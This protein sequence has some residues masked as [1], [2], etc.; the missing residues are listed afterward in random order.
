MYS[1]LK[2]NYKYSAIQCSKREAI[3]CNTV[4]EWHNSKWKQLGQLTGFL[5][6]NYITISTIIIMT[7]MFQ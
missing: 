4:A 5:T 6:R 3:K 1:L 2:L 7:A